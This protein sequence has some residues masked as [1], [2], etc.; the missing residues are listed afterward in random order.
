MLSSAPATTRVETVIPLRPVLSVVPSQLMLHITLVYLLPV[1]LMA[2][3]ASY[4][5][6]FILA[7]LKEGAE[8]DRDEDYAGNY[9]VSLAARYVTACAISNVLKCF[10][11]SPSLIQ[12]GVHGK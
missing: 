3:G 6:G 5:R 12:S 2:S 9:Q 10:V 11:F 8:G 4:F 1:T 7:A